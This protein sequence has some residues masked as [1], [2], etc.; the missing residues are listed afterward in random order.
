MVSG[1]MITIAGR[2]RGR[3]QLIF[4]TVNQ[5]VAFGLALGAQFSYLYNGDEDNR[6]CFSGVWWDLDEITCGEWQA[7]YLTS[8]QWIVLL[9]S[10]LQGQWLVSPE[11]HPW[12]QAVTWRRIWTSG[13]ETLVC[14]R[15]NWKQCW[16]HGC[17]EDSTFCSM[18]CC[19]L[20]EILNFWTRVP[21]FSFGIRPHK[22]CS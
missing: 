5:P 11:S 12:T 3:R 16:L 14:T 1:L 6:T 17:L 13:S 8:D 21:V 19:H 22:F 20:L 9:L 10:S 4:N 2:R 15:I 7:W 18:L